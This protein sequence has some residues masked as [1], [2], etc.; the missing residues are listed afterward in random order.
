MINKLRWRS[1][2]LIGLVSLLAISVL[3][4]SGCSLKASEV[5]KPL[6]PPFNKIIPTREDIALFYDGLEVAGG[7]ERPQI[8]V[9]VAKEYTWASGEDHVIYYHRICTVEAEKVKI[10]M[11]IADYSNE[12]DAIEYLQ[13]RVDGYSSVASASCSDR[14]EPSPDEALDYTYEADDWQYREPSEKDWVCEGIIFRVGRFVGHYE[15]TVY[16]P[17]IRSPGAASLSAS[18]L[19]Y[20]PFHLYLMLQWAVETTIPKL[21]SI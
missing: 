16:N 21:R 15:I 4:T 14:L 6:E 1:F 18:G 19:Y 7:H 17:P 13:N 11:Y 10:D 9:V 5:N 8:D 20:L 2:L 12:A 3:P